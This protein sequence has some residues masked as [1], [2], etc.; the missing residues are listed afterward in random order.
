MTQMNF[1]VDLGGGGFFRMVWRP[2]GLVAH[3]TL[4]DGTAQVQRELTKSEVHDIR[5]IMMTVDASLV[6]GP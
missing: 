6:P 2:D 4:S 3:M 1:H 5:N